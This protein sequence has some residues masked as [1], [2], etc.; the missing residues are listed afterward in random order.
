MPLINFDDKVTLNTNPGVADINKIK[1]SDINALKFGFNNYV[2]NGWLPMGATLAYTSWDATYKTGVVSTNIDL[3][4]VISVGMKILI[5]QSSVKYGIVTAITSNSM[6][7]FFGTDYTLANATITSCYYTLQSN[8][9]GFPKNPD[10]WSIINT[11][12]SAHAQSSPVLNTWYNL[13]SR[14]LNIPIG[15]W[16]VSYE[17]DFYIV[18][19]ATPIRVDGEVCLSTTNNGCTDNALKDRAIWTSGSL[20][21]QSF[22]RSKTL[23]LTTGTPYYLN[24]RYSNGSGVST[25]GSDGS[26]GTTVVIKAVCAYL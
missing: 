3:T 16:N 24:Y 20:V 26:A 6:T 21:G 17:S 2:A 9:F 5:V 8:P 10:K 7:I 18:F 25:M 22:Q 4:G 15:S 12:T 23:L 1:A 19:G 11:I 14:L 13:G